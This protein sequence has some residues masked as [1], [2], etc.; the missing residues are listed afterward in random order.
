MRKIDVRCLFASAA[1]LC[2]LALLLPGAS[3]GADAVVVTVTTN[4]DAVNGNVSSFQAL[5]LNPGADGI[6][7]REALL[8]TRNDPGQ[9]GIRFG[10]GLAGATIRV[11]SSAGGTLPALTGGGVSVDGDIDGDNR[12]DVTLLNEIAQGSRCGKCAFTIASS[13]N[14][15]H[16]IILQSFTTGVFFQPLSLNEGQVLTHQTYANNVVSNLAIN[17]VRE[18]GIAFS[19]IHGRSECASGIVCETHNSWFDTQLV[20][21]TIVGKHGVTFFASS[22]GDRLE[23]FTVSGNTIETSER[24]V[25]VVMHSIGVRVAAVTITGNRIRIT[26]APSA[27]GARGGVGLVAG[28]GRG[29]KENLLS[30]V[31]IA[32]NAVEGSQQ[33]AIRLSSGDNG[34][35]ANTVER[36]RILRNGVDL[37]PG[38]TATS[39]GQ[40]IVVIAGDAG[41]DYLHPDERPI[42][43]PDDNVV[44]DVEI[45]GNTLAEGIGVQ[46]GAGCCGA[47]RNT[48]QG[49]RITN[50]ELRMAGPYVGV[51][52]GGGSSGGIF[53]R[54]TT[55]GRVSGVSIDANRLAYPVGLI[56]GSLLDEAGIVLTG[57]WTANAGQIADASITRNRVENAT[58]G[59]SIIGGLARGNVTP[60]GATPEMTDNEIIRTVVQENVV[61]GYR[62]SGVLAVGGWGCRV[63]YSVRRNAIRRLKIERN[64]LAGRSST[65]GVEITGGDAC[66]DAVSEN[67]IED[68]SVAGNTIRGNGVGIR[69]LGGGGATAARNRVIRGLVARNRLTGNGV[70][71]HATNNVAG[72]RANAIDVRGLLPAVRYAGKAITRTTARLKVVVDPRGSAT[73]A[74]VRFGRSRAYRR[75]TRKRMISAAAGVR[76]IAV[77]ISGLRPGT[78]YHYRVIARSRSGTTTGR[79]ATFKTAKRRSVRRRA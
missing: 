28:D 18:A 8:V 20:G 53:S 59:I 79:G 50:N 45:S 73:T 1:W 22:I 30:D 71:V 9:Y 72:G 48:I 14:R 40:G 31:L 21:N 65:N 49:L 4:S 51:L 77:R 57:G 6:S 23:R 32:D 41:T 62:R 7:L 43:Y 15:L 58:N 2:L 54:A 61:S 12:P 29:S 66:R 47:A 78:N 13:G 19:S 10:P 16:A 55:A 75:A 68:V 26:A 60:R 44:R 70:A 64:T 42:V 76:T 5:V 63:D 37:R 69:V 52:V 33:T 17:D 24:G 56:G 36:I 25:N 34:A 74:F 11:G 3:T 38:A 39:I 46:V 27:P 67:R 35:T